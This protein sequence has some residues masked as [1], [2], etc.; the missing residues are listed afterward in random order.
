MPIGSPFVLLCFGAHIRPGFNPMPLRLH[1][2]S[3]LS[4]R[5]LDSMLLPC[6][7]RRAT[8]NS[9]VTTGASIPNAHCWGSAHDGNAGRFLQVRTVQQ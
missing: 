5:M 7:A 3:S 2:G 9:G 8:R 4:R 1:D 6:R